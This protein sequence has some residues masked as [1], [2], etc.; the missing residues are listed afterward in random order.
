MNNKGLYLW[1]FEVLTHWN[2][3]G[4]DD[5]GSKTCYTVASQ[6]FEGA[7]KKV[8]SIALSKSRKF[9]SDRCSGNE[10]VEPKFTFFPVSFEITKVERGSWI[11]G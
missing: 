10:V 1:D 4:P 9:V 2:D 11:D 8:G 7:C 3:E 6:T 5:D